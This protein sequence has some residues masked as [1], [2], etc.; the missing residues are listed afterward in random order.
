M[1][2]QLSLAFY[3]KPYSGNW[4]KGL[5][6][7]SKWEKRSFARQYNHWKQPKSIKQSFLRKGYKNEPNGYDFFLVEFKYILYAFDW[8]GKKTSK[9]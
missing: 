6:K 3:L 5:A 9:D 4:G 7:R 2:R 1:F 8:T